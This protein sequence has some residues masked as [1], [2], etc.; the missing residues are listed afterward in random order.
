MLIFDTRPAFPV[1]LMEKLAASKIVI[2]Q[3]LLIS[4][5]GIAKMPEVGIRFRLNSQ[6][7]IVPVVPA[8]KRLL[9]V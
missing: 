5:R 1:K 4:N 6:Q 9:S 7:Y 8:S 2:T 3:I